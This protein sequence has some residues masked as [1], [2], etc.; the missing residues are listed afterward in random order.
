VKNHTFH[1]IDGHTAGMPVR[2]VVAGAPKLIGDTQSDRRQHFLD[3]YDWIRKA[4]MLEPRGHDVMS[5]ALLYPPSSEDFDLGLVF[6]ETSGSLPMC[7]HGTIG[8]VTFALERGL[9]E[10]ER[11]GQVRVETPAG[12]VLADYDQQGDKVESVRLTNVPSFLLHRDLVFEF[13]P[14][15]TLTLDI[16]YGGNFYLIIEP[17]QNYKGAS[18]YSVP[19]LCRMGWQLQ[20]LINETMDVVHPLDANICGVKHCMWTGHPTQPGSDGR[21]VVIA[22]KSL[23]DR[24]PCGTGTSARMAQRV[25]R[26]RQKIG[27]RYVHESVIGSQ[28]TGCAAGATRVGELDAIIPTVQ[29][30]AW[31]TGLNTL[32]VNA[33]EPF[34]E[35]FRV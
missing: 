6:I 31:I 8:S 12:L 14:L 33:G 32:F 18:D 11:S 25:A 17:Q 23:V 35:G 13:D 5:G 22:G 28:F 34:P 20:C 4:L 2:L 10:P 16:A 7:G 1:C 19:D 26:G 9:V 30:S 24:S 15:G 21:S 3:E 29:G 27:E